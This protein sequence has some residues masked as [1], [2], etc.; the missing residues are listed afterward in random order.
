[1]QKPIDGLTSLTN[2]L[3]DKGVMKI[4]LYSAIARQKLKPIQKWA[5]EQKINGRSDTILQ[6]REMI[7]KSNIG[8]LWDPMETPAAIPKGGL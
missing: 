1:M 2:V 5:K 6:V 3:H 4:S 7:K 8:A